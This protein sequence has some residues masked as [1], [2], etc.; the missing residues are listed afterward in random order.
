MR[1]GLF[2]RDQFL[3]RT[4]LLDKEIDEQQALKNKKHQDANTQSRC[5]R[6]SGVTSGWNAHFLTQPNYQKQKG[7]NSIFRK[8]AKIKG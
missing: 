7:F 8:R 3:V 1:K 4:K 6:Y 5:F 2:H